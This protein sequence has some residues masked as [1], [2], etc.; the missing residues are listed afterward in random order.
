MLQGKVP[1]TSNEPDTDKLDM[2]D[3]KYIPGDI[4]SMYARKRE[5]VE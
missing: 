2:Q 5:E 4:V 3:F 1:D